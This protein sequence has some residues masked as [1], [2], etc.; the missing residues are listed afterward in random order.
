[1]DK[2]QQS[3]AI[4][5]WQEIKQYFSTLLVPPTKRNKAELIRLRASIV[6]Y[7]GEKQKLMEVLAAHQ[8]PQV[9]GSV[10]AEQSLDQ[11]PGLLERIDGINASLRNLA[12]DANLFA[13]E[14]AFRDLVVTMQ[15]KR[16]LTLCSIRKEAT[17]GFGN[18]QVLENLQ[19]QLASELKAITSAED[20][21]ASYIR[22]LP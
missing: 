4:N 17:S 13:A 15:A 11:I 12:N 3:I 8:P 14:P 21:L 10:A 20:A 7:E 5:T 1:V 18:K 9:S 16:S 6:S 2:V 22:K 19:L